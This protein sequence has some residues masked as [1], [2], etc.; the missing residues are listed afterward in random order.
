M[1][2][3]IDGSVAVRW[4]FD[5]P[6]SQAARGLLLRERSGELDLVAPELIGAEVVNAIWKK[7]RRGQCSALLALEALTLWA[8]GRPELLPTARLE[9]VALDLALQLGHSAY[10]CFYL[11][12]A[13][14]LSASLATADVR[15]ATLARR[16][17]RGVELV[18]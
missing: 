4:C 14:D 8:E 17:V 10:D 6:G 9:P 2:L 5:E 13:L 15:L 3:V 18:A 12:A 16:V 7:V 11:A 1:R